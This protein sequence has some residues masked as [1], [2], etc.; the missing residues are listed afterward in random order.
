[1]FDFFARNTI[2]K[3]NVVSNG[4]IPMGRKPDLST[5]DKDELIRLMGLPNHLRQ[6][7][8]TVIALGEAT[9]TDVSKQTGKSRASE[10]DYMNQLERMGYLKRRYA[11]RKVYFSPA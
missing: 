2:N 9:A 5:L 3:G 7:M 8:L 1:M 11:K 10:S 6:T 4:V